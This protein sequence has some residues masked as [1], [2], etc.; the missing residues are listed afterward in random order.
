MIRRVLV[1]RPEPG[2]TAT[3]RTLA[4]RGFEPV[5]SPLLT[6]EAAPPLRPAVIPQAVLV[7]SANALPALAPMPGVGLFAVGDATAAVAGSLGWTTPRSAGGDAACLLALCR[8]E[9]RPDGGAL[10]LL[11]GEGQGDALASGLRASG[12]VVT[13]AVAYAQRPVAAFPAAASEAL[14]TGQVEAALFFSPS[15]ARL[16]RSLLPVSL[17]PALGTV[18]ALAIS[19]AAAEPLRALRWRRMRVASRPNSAGVLALL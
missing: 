10:L 15:A 14:A 5:A 6:I 17:G 2:C 13:V 3:C 1:T 8:A 18:A 4:D 12:F 7:T 19:E 11:A 16:F 9:L